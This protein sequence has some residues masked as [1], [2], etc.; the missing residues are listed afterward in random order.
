MLNIFHNRGV[1]AVNSRVVTLADYR[2]TPRLRSAIEAFFADKQLS[3]NSR[4][5]YSPSSI[6]PLLEDLWAGTFPVDQLDCSPGYWMPSPRAVGVG[7]AC[8]L[9]HPDHRYPD[10]SSLT[11]GVTRWLQHDPVA[12]VVP[13]A[14]TPRSD[15]S[16]P[17]PRPGKT[18]VP[19]RHRACGRRPCGGCCTR[20]PPGPGKSSPSTSR[21]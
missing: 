21:T 15:Q 9:E 19:T 17:L 20:P 3:A 18:L 4:R 2:G 1:H 14:A 11:A 13:S 6:R 12:L 16:H 8:H 7:T 10:R 5:A